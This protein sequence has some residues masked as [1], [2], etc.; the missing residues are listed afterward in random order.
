MPAEE[1]ENS[2]YNPELTHT[3]GSI[4]IK[5][6]FASPNSD[7]LKGDFLN[8]G[9]EQVWTYYHN[10]DKFNVGGS[11]EVPQFLQ[12]LWVTNF[13]W[14]ATRAYKNFTRSPWGDSWL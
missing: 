5:N 14:F 12:P 11:N 1:K 2:S 6:L 3:G 10:K 7:Q 8:M 4:G 9:S 13:S